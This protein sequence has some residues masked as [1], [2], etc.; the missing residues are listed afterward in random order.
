[1]QTEFHEV[2]CKGV[3]ATPQYYVNICEQ[4]E[5]FLGI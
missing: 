3:L 4:R 1:M 5:L 2:E